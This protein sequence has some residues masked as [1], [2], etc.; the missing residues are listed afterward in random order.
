M[1]VTRRNLLKAAFGA[2]QL[3][4]IDKLGVPLFGGGRARANLPEGVPTKLLTI[5]IPGGWVPYY[6]WV[7][8]TPQEITSHIPPVENYLN[9]EPVFY[10]PDDITNLDGSGDADV[11]ATYMRLRGPEQ[12]NIPGAS[13][14]GRAWKDYAL[15]E[16]A[17]VVHG[18]DVGTADHFSARVSMMSGKASS[19]YQTPAVHAWVA[20][21]THALYG[22]NRPLASVAI[23]SGPIPSPASLGAT[24]AP[25]VV[26]S[27]PALDY[28][29]GE[30]LD[31]AWEGLRNRS[32][33][34]QI[35]FDGSP[36]GQQLPANNME[37]HSL[38]RL[39]RLHDTVN[40]A[41]DALYQR[42]FDTYSGVSKLLAQDLIAQ[43]AATPG[44]LGQSEITYP[45]WILNSGWSSFYGSKAASASD[46]QGATA[47]I[48]LTLKLLRSGLTSAVSME[49]RGIQGFNFDTHGS[50]HD[51]QYAYLR[52]AYDVVGRI[53][54]QMKNIQVSAGKSLLDDTLVV[55][56]SEFA[57]TWPHSMT[58]D[59]WPATSVCF[60]G[61][62]V[63]PNRQIGRFNIPPDGETHGLG[64]MGDDVQLIG[65]GGGSMVRPPTSGDVVWTILQHMGLTPEYNSS[66]FLGGGPGRF[67]GLEA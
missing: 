15:W 64:Y 56:Q 42:I 48:E 61:G 45:D 25:T 37:N 6:L 9:A 50:G 2:S 36:T 18:I 19:T 52:A 16:N 67:V 40:P 7:P 65:E 5:H 10:G 63:V 49:L 60:A 53:I 57:R 47:D 35:N 26:S 13:Q 34:P 33:F 58:C 17:S 23:G 27:L 20:W 14:N 22:D 44:S 41:T 43:I 29:L 55:V 39:S 1:K 38:A 54:A 32:S 21:A 8:F 28:T 3:A 31:S 24:G 66:I 12:W 62:Q 51:T 30:K 46:S 4:L 11:N 59:H